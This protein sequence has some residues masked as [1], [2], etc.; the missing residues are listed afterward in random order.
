[1]AHDRE[2]QARRIRGDSR[3]QFYEIRRNDQTFGAQGLI[4]RLIKLEK[5][6]AERRIEL[7]DEQDRLLERFS[8]EFRERQVETRHTGDLVAVDTFCVG[9]GKVYLH[10]VVDCLSRYAWGRLYPNTTLLDE[11][12]RLR[13][14]TKLHHSIEGMHK[15]S[16]PI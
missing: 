4:D 15:N 8:P 10:T 6:T 7:T 12:F 1:M 5:T 16:T 9:V 2:S 11:H 3:Q 13:D 14:R